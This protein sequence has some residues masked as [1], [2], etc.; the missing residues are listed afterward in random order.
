MTP[1]DRAA[2]RFRGVHGR[3][4][5]GVWSAPGRVNLIGEHT[6][7]NDGF[8]LP[9]ALPHRVAVAASPRTDG[10]I[11]AITVGDDGVPQRAQPVPVAELTPGRVTG[12]A[13]YVYGVAWALR[14]AGYPTAA[15]LVITG[16]VPTGAGLS[17]SHA[18]QCAVAL[19][20]LG[21]ADVTPAPDPTAALA[22]AGSRDSSQAV[23]NASHEPLASSGPSLDQVARWVQ[24]S[25]NEFVGAPTGL[26]D[27]T[28]SLR[29]VVGHALFLDVR[30]GAAEHIPFDAPVLVI[31]TRVRHAL[32]DSAYG[33]RRRG[34]ERAAALLGVPSLREVDTGVDLGRLPEDLRP[35]VRHVVTENERVLA[36]VAALRAGTDIG[37]PLT[38]SHA[39]LRDDYRV[40][41]RELDVA[42][43]AALGAGALG[44]RMT[45]GGFGGSAIAVVPPAVDEAVRAAVRAAFA[46][47]SLTA[48]RLFAAAPSAGAGRDH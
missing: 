6:D 29:C 27:Q 24:R 4:P 33:D 8:V 34:C 47:R 1:A 35:L 12:W 10:R 7:Y 2:E 48:P 3:A 20:L 38:A 19:A 26:L 23:S 30:S 42:V 21:L 39:S 9:F 32:A 40:S 16:D 25:E 11:T 15:D 46:E 18:L 41:C 5:F 22:A 36:T 13:A 43:E 28:A 17:S 31:D 37:E 44:A 14:D 45:G